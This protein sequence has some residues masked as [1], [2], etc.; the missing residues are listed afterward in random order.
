M[1][2]QGPWI[3]GEEEDINP[4]E[5][6]KVEEK[7]EEDGQEDLQG[8]EEEVEKPKKEEKFIPKNLPE[9]EE[10]EFVDI[11]DPIVQKKFN[12]LYSQIKHTERTNKQLMEDNRKLLERFKDM[13]ARFEDKSFTDSKKEL[14]SQLDA[15]VKDRKAAVDNGDDERAYEITEQIIEL[16]RELKAEKPVK[17]KEKEPEPQPEEE[18]SLSDEDRATLADWGFERDKR[19]NL[20]RPWFSEDHDDHIVAK[21][22][23][24]AI[25]EEAGPKPVSIGEFLIELDRRMSRFYNIPVQK[26]TSVRDGESKKPSGPKLSQEQMYVARKMFPDYKPDEAI[27]LYMEGM[28][29]GEW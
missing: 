19:G 5:E 23:A 18:F 17:E 26:P 29:D 7:E 3:D 14:Q 4:N 9:D 21:K 13:E 6:T 10:W 24:E 12:R 1:G 2:G 27:K 20:K 25:L 8:R 15:L 22:M 16:K 11:K 28:S